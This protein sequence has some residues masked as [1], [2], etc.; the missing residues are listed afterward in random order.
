MKD[1]LSLLRTTN[2]PVINSINKITNS[3]PLIFSKI[4]NAKINGSNR[5]TKLPKI[6]FPPKKLLTLESFKG[7]PKILYP[8]KN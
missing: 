5:V 6:S 3:F 1:N 7:N 8:K 4:I 2:I